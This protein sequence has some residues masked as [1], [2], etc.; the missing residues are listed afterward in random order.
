MQPPGGISGRLAHSCVDVRAPGMR[1]RHSH[2]P[3]S[4]GRRVRKIAHTFHTGLAMIR[5]SLLRLAPR[6]AIL[7]AVAVAPLGAQIV[8]PRRKILPP[9][10]TSTPAQAAV[11][12]LTGYEIVAGAEVSVEPLQ[13]ATP[14][15]QCPAGKLPVGGGYDFRGPADAAYGFEMRGVSAYRSGSNYMHASAR[16]ANLGVRGVVRAYAVCI[17]PPAGTRQ[18]EIY[19]TADNIESETKCGDT[20]RVIGGGA[21]GDLLT[22]LNTS[23]PQGP[24]N[25]VG[26][27][28]T[29]WRVQ[30]IKSGVGA[31]HSITG[32]LVCAAATAVDGWENVRSAPVGIGARGRAQLDLRC[33]AGKMMLVAGVYSGNTTPDLVVN[34]LM[35]A[36]DG[37]ATAL[38]LNR[39]IAGGQVFPSL[40]AV[41]ARVV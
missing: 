37:S 15:A 10:T 8:V 19:A 32:S 25:S 21:N 3:V 26:W 17:T 38:V 18:I 40:V 20:E 39:S 2:Q 7:L 27:S 9:P 36:S 34:R 41:C 33:P 35:I 31:S 23:I 4:R 29:G 11:T 24:A 1:R 22:Q 13:L 16:N 14:T 6:V 30:A 12:A 5:P 28:G